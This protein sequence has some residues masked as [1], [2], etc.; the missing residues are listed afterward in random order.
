MEI[1]M[2]QTKIY[3]LRNQRVMLDF[4]LAELYGVPTKVLKQSV[5]RN[6]DRFPEDFMFELTKEEHLFLRSQIVTLETGR[7]KFSKYLPFAFTEHGV[8]MLSSILNSAQAIKVNIAVVRA[9][10]SLRQYA[11]TYAELAQKLAEL[12]AK[13]GKDIADI[14]EVL[15]WLGEENQARATEITAIGAASVVWENRRPIGFNK[16]D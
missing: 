6:M 5:K 1:Q 4:D 3:S 2:I 12:E 8:A 10:I 14:H 13:T 7:G 16:E 11:L 15:R 9:F